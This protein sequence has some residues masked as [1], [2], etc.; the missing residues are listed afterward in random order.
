MSTL[1][2]APADRGKHAR[3]LCECTCLHGRRKQLPRFP[4]DNF[5]QN[6]FILRMI[7]P[8]VHTSRLQ[9]LV[10]HWDSTLC[11]QSWPG[12]PTCSSVFS[13]LE[14]CQLCHSA[15]SLT[16]IRQPVFAK[17]RATAPTRVCVCQ[18]VRPPWSLRLVHRGLAFLRALCGIRDD[19]LLFRIKYGDSHY[20]AVLR[21]I[22]RI[23]LVK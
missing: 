21:I 17:V 20:H 12:R 2:A 16:T 14:F 9:F 5:S 11:G 8:S 15:I 4:F 19:F 18:S 7:V 22:S 13:Q 3:C 1:R 6:Y 23:S 10:L